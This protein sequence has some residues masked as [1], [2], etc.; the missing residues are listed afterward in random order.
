MPLLLPLA[1]VVETSS[2]SGP[3][4]VETPLTG[5]SLLGSFDLEAAAFIVPALLLSLAAPLVASRFAGGRRVAVHALGLVGAG[6]SAWGASLVLF[7]SLFSTRELLPA[8]LAVLV[9]FCSGVVDALGRLALGLAEW[10]AA[11]RT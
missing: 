1:W 3:A 8:G 7:F 11:R 9:L 10:R 2:C 5:L 4:P 6:L